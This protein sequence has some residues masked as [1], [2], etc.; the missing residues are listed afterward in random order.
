MLSISRII[1]PHPRSIHKK[2]RLGTLVRDMVQFPP[3]IWPILSTLIYFNPLALHY[4]WRILPS[5]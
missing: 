4:F 1:P 5:A 3:E 2:Q